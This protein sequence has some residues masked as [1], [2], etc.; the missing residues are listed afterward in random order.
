MGNRAYGEAPGLVVLRRLFRSS[1]GKL[2]YEK[3]TVRL[4]T[5]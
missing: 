5:G 2:Q 3:G 1:D 4:L